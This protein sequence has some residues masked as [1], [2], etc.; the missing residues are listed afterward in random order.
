MLLENHFPE[1]VRVRQ[2]A[3]KL[4]EYGYQVTVLAQK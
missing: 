2:E 3:Y 1:D 4:V